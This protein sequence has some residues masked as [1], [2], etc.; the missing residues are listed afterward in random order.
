MAKQKIFSVFDKKVGAYK[1]PFISD[2]EVEATRGLQTA[3]RDPEI[4]ISLFPEDFDLY[5]MGIFNDNS[6]LIEPIIPPLY[7]CSAVEFKKVTPP[8][9]S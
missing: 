1:R 8:N 6:G 3:M 5:E 2:N 9:K 7:I 4:Q